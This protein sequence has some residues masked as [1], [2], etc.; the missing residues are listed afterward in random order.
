MKILKYLL[1]VLLALVVIGVILGLVGPKTYDISRSKVIAS[2][3]EQIWPYLTSFQKAHAWTP[4]A[5][6]DTTMTA[7]YS[8]EDGAVGS[9]LSWKSK[10]MGGGEQTITALDP[11]KSAD[12]ELKFFQPWGEGHAT[13]YYHLMDTLGGTKVTWGMHGENGFVNRAM[14]A[15]MNMDKMMGPIFLSGLNNL[16]SIMATL[17][18]T[19]TPDMKINTEEYP[20]GK[21]LGIRG[22][23]KISKLS[24][25]FSANMTKLMDGVKKSGAEMSGMPSGLYYVWEPD[26]DNTDVAAAI[27]IKND[28][29][30]PAGLSFFTLPASKVI[31]M[32]YMGGYGGLGNAH[33][34]MA[35]YI[36]SNNLTQSAPVIEEYIVDPAMEK[37]S[38]KWHT[39]IMYFV[40]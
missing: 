28:V 29:K 7:E 18:K 32:D 24:D 37:D 14:A 40:K 19:T 12:S 38:T 1:Y 9:K 31:T 33:G 17:P 30:A 36:K 20:G 6:M 5:R 23:A 21:Y 4:F 26:K 39:R 27:A 3:P 34:A 16:D 35:T 22:I 15:L 10:K 25:F 13:A 8:G 11:Y 2:S